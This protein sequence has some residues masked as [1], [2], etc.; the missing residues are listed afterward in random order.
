MHP[1]CA[2]IPLLY[3]HGTVVLQFLLRYGLVSKAF[4]LRHNAHQPEYDL[5]QHSHF[6]PIRP[7]FYYRGNQMMAVRVGQYKAHYW[8]WSN[9]WEEFNKVSE[10]VILSVSPPSH[11][12]PFVYQSYVQVIYT[13]NKTLLSFSR[14]NT[15]HISL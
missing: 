15:I 5:T 6:T 3:L 10:T 8:T 1:Q 2:L 9:S 11:P 13:D 7:I 4:H 12:A 14:A